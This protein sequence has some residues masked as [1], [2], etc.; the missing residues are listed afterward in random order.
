[1][2]IPG[3][4]II[5][6]IGQGGMASVYLAIQ[7][8][9]G[10]EVAL[11]L[12]HASMS[13]DA[14]FH[15]RFL[16]E[17]QTVA[18]F[19]HPNIVTIYDFGSHE[20]LHYFTMELFP[21]GTL[22]ERIKQG[23]PLQEMLGISRLLAD[24][25]GYAHDEGVVH[26]D[27]KPKNILFRENGAPVLTDFGIAKLL[28]FNSPLT[29][30]GFTVGSPNY[31]SPEQISGK[32]IDKRSDIY[33][34]GVLFYH[35][36]TQELPYQAEDMVSMAMKHCMAPLP[37]LNDELKDF[38]SLVE[39]MLAKEPDDRFSSMA[40]L[41][42]AIDDII[43]LR[44][45]ISG[46]L[47]TLRLS[48][49]HLIP[50][51]S[52]RDLSN[53]ETKKSP[54]IS[55]ALD[56]S[57]SKTT[58]SKNSLPQSTASNR[59]LVVALGF[60]ALAVSA[61]GGYVFYQTTQRPKSQDLTAYL[62]LPQVSDIRLAA[63]IDYE[64]LALGHLNEREFD[65]SLELI[66]LGLN[67]APDDS[68]LQALN[69]QVLRLRE[70][71]LLLEQARQ[72]FEKG[73]WQ[74]SL[75][76]ARQGLEQVPE[77]TTLQR[78]REKA[79]LALREQRQK[80]AEQY[81]TL[82]REQQRHGALEDSLDLV[83]R[84]LEQIPNHA[85]LTILRT[86]IESQLQRRQIATERLLEARKS[87]E[88]GD[89]QTSLN[90]IEDGLSQVSDHSELLALRL[91]A[92]AALRERELQAQV[93][94]MLVEARERQQA[95]QFENSLRLID[96][97]LAKIPDQPELI[98]LRIQV[99]AQF[100]HLQGL[101]E[102]V[103]VAVEE[104]NLA[105]SLRLVDEGLALASDHAELLTLRQHINT[106]IERR[107]TATRDLAN[108]Q[109]RYPLESLTLEQG[110]AALDCY[111]ALQSFI[112][113]NDDIQVV[114][115]ALTER[116][117]DWVQ[118]Y[119]TE[120]RFDQA[121]GVLYWLNALDFGKERHTDLSQQL[122]QRRAY[123]D[124][125]QRLQE[126]TDLDLA[127]ARELYRQGALEASLRR[128]DEGLQR[129]PEHEAMLELRATVQNQIDQQRQAADMLA[130]ARQLQAQDAF[131]ES[132]ERIDA[133]L[134]LVPNQTDLLELRKRVQEQYAEAQRRKQLA[135]VLADAN[136]LQQN[137]QL[138]ASLAAV[139]NGITRF[140]DEPSLLA[141]RDS[142][143]K[144]IAQ[145]ERLKALLAQAQDAFEQNQFEEST[146]LI[147]EGLAIDSEDAKL[148][149]LQT[150]INKALEQQAKSEQLLKEC[151]DQFPLSELAIQQGEDALKCYLKL[152]ALDVKQA[153]VVDVLQQLS[154]IYLDW[155]AKAL[156]QDQ[157]EQAETVLTWVSQLNVGVSTQ[158][159][160]SLQRDLRAKQAAKAAA[161]QPTPQ[162]RQQPTPQPRQQ[163]TP[164]PR[165]QPTP[166][167]R[168]Q[169]AP[170]PRQQPTPQPRQQ[171]TPQ[172]RQQPA[173]QPRQQPQQPRQ[174][175][176]PEPAPQPEQQPRPPRFFGTF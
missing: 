23:I 108:C 129:L 31:M 173:P 14:N 32:K 147:E 72:H 80:K 97:G 20:K 70:A 41:I 30:T 77:Y 11:K 100:E 8:S 101:I 150:Q 88:G 3:Y 99:Q 111:Q 139:E 44:F 24:A 63:V 141:L 9:L 21:E 10:R 55:D 58:A 46:D 143:Q 96:Q 34:F 134:R 119:I 110:A 43:R 164:Q 107:A 136:A 152:Q 69:Q 27:I 117:A 153:K 12:M 170:Q 25:I 113:D 156:E 149:N 7:E 78:L 52:I 114:L 76:I 1:M 175:P 35:M 162:P 65:N 128:I 124:E 95:G 145:R 17:A 151:S 16:N 42:D 19:R 40:E 66:R 132:L 59:R 5:K 142:I 29:V 37:I 133:G 120:E 13:A 68:R 146:R 115:L 57:D 36:L 92:R 102:Q 154:T 86:T 148:L 49:S 91:Q 166:Q 109:Q 67:I 118:A 48:G 135:Q 60:A 45:H 4:Q 2:D 98:E 125:R 159:L 39:R 84:G 167:P 73:E 87:L 33:S 82:A 64:R 81:L 169:P 53:D 163:P 121:A 93:N 137:N 75:E 56:H 165:Q 85:Q 171:P 61:G 103:R 74:T 89:I 62:T 123:F 157:L 71:D 112:D 106:I 90:L 50:V 161:T 155:I 105:K 83:Q 172:P 160:E 168:Q 126:A 176:E 140:G 28:D 131:A 26:R 94:E 47:P 15:Q 122:Q 54:T 6:Q 158:R 22:A 174:Q 116:F 144:T 38:Q 104:Q 127:Q 51:S 79:E 138:E 18:R 130:E